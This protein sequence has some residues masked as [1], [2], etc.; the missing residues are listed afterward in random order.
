M[1][2]KLVREQT[3][4]LLKRKIELFNAIDEKLR[5]KTEI[6]KEFEIANSTLLMIIKTK[7]KS[8]QC[9]SSVCLNWRE[10]Q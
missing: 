5:T 3:A 7:F 1:A 10:R 2:E 9:L 6:C 4:I 8:H